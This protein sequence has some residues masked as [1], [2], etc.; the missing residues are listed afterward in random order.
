MAHALYALGR[1]ALAA[2]FIWSGWGKL[3]A[4]EGLSMMLAG[5]GLPMPLYLAYAAG[6]AEI[7][8]GALVVIGWQARLAAVGLIA[9]T[10]AATYLAHD[11]WTQTGATA[12]ANQIHAM[13]NLAVIG[14]LLMLA[15]GGPGRFALGR[16]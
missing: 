16:R 10:V 4:P 14:G 9:F 11:F 12:R 1:V 2:L 8:L 15:A 7:V 3:V 6:L 5:R 13:K